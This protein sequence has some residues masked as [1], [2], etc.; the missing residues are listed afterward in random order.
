MVDYKSSGVDIEE[1]YRSVEKIREYAKMTLSPLVLNT[2]GSFAGMMEIPEGYRRPVLISGTDGVGTKLRIAFDTGKYDTVGIDCV[3]MCVN[4]ILCHGARPMFFLDY[5][6]CGKL[7]AEVSSELVKGVAEGCL[8][9]GLSLIGGET[10]EMPGFYA[11]GDYDMAGFAVGVAEKEEIITG[12]DIRPGDLIIGLPSSGFHSNGF[13]LLRKVF[14]D[15]SEP[16]ME[17]TIGDYLLT[18]TRIYTD[19]VM[20]SLEKFRIKGMAHVTGGGF[21][22]NL[23]RMLVNESLRI[24]V[25]KDSYPLPPIYELLAQRGVSE[26]TF[27]NTFNTGIG[28]TFCIDPGDMEAFM[29]FLASLGESPVEL[30]YIDEGEESICLR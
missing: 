19:T 26:E 24:N 12:E 30:G 18:P 10:A 28:Y 8:Q 6:A 13:S 27:Y 14:A 21:I 7:D 15:F 4:D 2:L 20:K 17:R 5:I 29:D 16:Y 23:P 3:A 9:G 1:G 22:E 25:I 11:E